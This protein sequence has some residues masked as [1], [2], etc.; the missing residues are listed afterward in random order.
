MQYSYKFYQNVL[1]KP[2]FKPYIPTF[3]DTKYTKFLLVF[4]GSD[5][6]ISRKLSLRTTCYCFLTYMICIFN[7]RNSYEQDA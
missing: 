4:W 5:V 6:H 1:K 7:F 2:S 3:T